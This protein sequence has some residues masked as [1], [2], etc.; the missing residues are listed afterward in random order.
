MNK[1][2]HSHL[3]TFK[4]RIHQTQVNTMKKIQSSRL[5]KRMRMEI[6]SSRR[7]D[8]LVTLAEAMTFKFL[9]KIHLTL[10]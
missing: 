3:M 6:N 8:Q 2:R 10:N 1:S 7:M 5:Q 4:M 9:K